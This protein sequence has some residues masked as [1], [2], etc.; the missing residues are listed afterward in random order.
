MQTSFPKE[1][2][3]TTMSY[4]AAIADG[5]FEVLSADPRTGIVFSAIFGSTPYRPL[6]QR[7]AD[8]F[9][10]RIIEPPFSEAATAGLGA[11][12][13]MVGQRLLVNFATATFSLLGLSQIANEAAV[14][15]YMSG[16]QLKVPVVYYVL[17]GMRGG[18]GPQ[19]SSSIHS[20]FWNC[21]GLELVLPS[22]PADAK[23]L[24]I[25]SLQSDN[26]TF[27]FTHS[28]LFG[29]EGPVPSG[30]VPTPLGVA[31][32][33]RPGRDVT[34]VAISY[35]VPIALAAATELAKRGIEAE[36]V[37]PRTLV[38]LDETTILGSVARTG[39]LVVVDECPLR[40]GA[41]SEIAATV[42]ERGFAYLK[43]P[44]VRVARADVPTPFSPA[45]EA[46]LVPDSQRIVDVVEALVL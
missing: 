15:R 9:P 6:F 12:A 32:V 34:I 35:M 43:A 18:G 46:K 1:T 27:F 17:H 40:C 31:D 28:K 4:A 21:P 26:P 44:P 36:V 45:L 30:L 41:A 16:G 7:I 2:A 42:A 8:T 14:A 38:P 29:L 22:D 23:G 39:R 3:T 24:L 13:A 19:H 10:D 20:M 11:G 33:K 37:D 5:L 25:A